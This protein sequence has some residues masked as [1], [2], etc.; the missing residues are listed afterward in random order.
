MAERAAGRAPEGICLTKQMDFV[1]M[2]YFFLS[3]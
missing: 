1:V 2:F 3:K